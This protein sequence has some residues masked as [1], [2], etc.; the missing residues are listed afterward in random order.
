MSGKELLSSLFVHSIL[1]TQSIM[2]VENVSICSRSS[3]PM[4]WSPVLPFQ[5][6]SLECCSSPVNT[7]HEYDAIATDQY[8]HMEES[9]LPTLPP[10]PN[11]PT[12]NSHD[13]QGDVDTEI[14]DNNTRGKGT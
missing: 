12:P 14:V 13:V 4:H 3:L 5:V 2:A 6:A 9:N 10:R 8:I 7:N 11:C 1:S